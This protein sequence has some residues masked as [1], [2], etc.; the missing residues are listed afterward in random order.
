LLGV[1]FNANDVQ[2]ASKETFSMKNL[3]LFIDGTN[4]DGVRDLPKSEATN[5]YKLYKMCQE[6]NPFYFQGVGSGRMGA[7]GG[8]TGFG[9]KRR[10]KLAYEYLVLNYQPGDNIYLFGFSRGAFAVR[11]LAGFLGYVG[12][13]FGKPPFNDYLPHVYQI[14]ESSVALD[15]VDSFKRYVASLGEEIPK[16]IPIHFIGVWDTVERYF[17]VRDLPEIKKLPSHVTHARHALAIHERR[18]EMAPTL[19]TGWGNN[20]TVRQMWFPGAHADVGGGYSDDKLAA[21]PLEW[22]F[23]EAAFKGLNLSGL[24]ANNQKRILHQQRT[25]FPFS[26]KILPHL[27]GESI[28]SALGT[29]TSPVIDSMRVHQTAR[30]HLGPKAIPSSDF[31]FSKHFTP[32]DKLNAVSEVAKVDQQA[33]ILMGRVVTTP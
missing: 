22:M 1:S 23:T 11:L 10:L 12:T 9:T 21:A 28:R 32:N 29:S 27:E 4:N 26:G 5:V 17:P 2:I 14:Y 15:V 6:P 13:L 20:Q 33:R 3:A 8:S 25:D 16:P 30:D 18:N 7:L 19:W 24:Q 31:K